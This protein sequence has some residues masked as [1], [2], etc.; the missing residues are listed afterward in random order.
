[1]EKIRK[2]IPVAMLAFAMAFILSNIARALYDNPRPFVVG[3]FEPLIPHEPDNGFPSDHALLFSAIASVVM[4]Y[5]RKLSIVFW[6]LAVAISLLRVYAGVHHLVDV[7]ASFVISIVSTLA[8][9]AIISKL[10]KHK[11]HTSSPS[12]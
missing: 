2:I 6:I 1:M 3:S 4:L 5:N 8:A 10:W 12:L 11:N 9:Y 7:L